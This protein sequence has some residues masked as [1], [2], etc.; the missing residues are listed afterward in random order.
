MFN[1]C[2]NNDYTYHKVLNNKEEYEKETNETKKIKLE[3]KIYD[4]NKLIISTKNKNNIDKY[5][6]KIWYFVICFIIV[7]IVISLLLNSMYHGLIKP[8]I[9]TYA[10][11]TQCTYKFEWYFTTFVFIFEM[12]TITIQI[13]LYSYVYL[14]HNNIS[15][16]TT[17]KYLSFNKIIVICCTLLCILLVIVMVNNKHIS[18]DC[19]HK[20]NKFDFIPFIES[21]VLLW[22]IH[23]LSFISIDIFEE[24]YDNKYEE[25]Q[26]NNKKIRQEIEKINNEYIT[27][28]IID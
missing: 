26:E 18:K 28:D 15:I 17:C 14:S 4:N 19:K 7:S 23:V 2:K 11:N 27:V 22:V 12:I 5:T 20:Y 16:T 25:L 1:C 21:S 8:I 24:H 13:Y 3:Q 10:Y 6:V 9:S